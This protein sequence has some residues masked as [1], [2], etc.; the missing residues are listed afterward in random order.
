MSISLRHRLYPAIVDLLL[1]LLAFA[2]V[3]SY[4]YDDLFFRP[5]EIFLLQILIALWLGV[6]LF[7]NKFA[8]FLFLVL[9]AVAFIL[10]LS[11]RSGSR[12]LKDIE[13]AEEAHAMITGDP[14][15][16]LPP[17]PRCQVNDPVREKLEHALEFFNL[18]IFTLID[19]HVDLQSINRCECSLLSTDN[20]FSLQPLNIEGSGLII[21]LHK[22]NDIRCCIRQVLSGT[23][24][25]PSFHELKPRARSNTAIPPAKNRRMM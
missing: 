3:Q 23:G 9:E 5:Q 18:D 7:Y 20:L 17:A 13:S 21:N 24:F 14:S 1:L 19:Q 8:L 25:V 12:Q 22:I 15:R 10:Y 2:A 4:K 11:W 16:E 6:S